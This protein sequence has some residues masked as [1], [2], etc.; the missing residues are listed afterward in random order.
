MDDLQLLRRFVD[1]NSQ[2]AFAALTSR[3][4]GLV[5][6]VCRRELADDQAAEDV[7]QA[8]FLILARKAPILG[9]GVVLSGWLF[10]T[11]RF[12]AKNAR[13]QAQRRTAYEGEAAAMRHEQQQEREDAVWAGIEPVLNQSLA[14]L[15][16]GER[17]CVLLRFFQGL[18]FAEA[19]AALGLSEDTARKRVGRA[20]EKMRRFF[21]KEG[22]IVPGALL[23]ALLTARAAEAV[24]ATLS[25]G[26]P[27]PH[28]YQ[29]STGVLHA[30]KIIQIKTVA[31]VG[32]AATVALGTTYSVARGVSLHATN[33]SKSSVRALAAMPAAAKQGHV[34]A[35]APGKALTAAQ[36]TDRCRAAYGALKSYQGTTTVTSHSTAS[37]NPT[38]GEYRASATI[39]FVRPGKIRAEGKDMSGYPYAYVSDGTATAYQANA[40]KGAWKA[41]PN[42][43]MAIA[44]VTGIAENAA[45][46]VPA[47]LLGAG[48]G[49]PFTSGIASEI[50]EDAVDGHPC[51]V[52]TSSLAK[53]TASMAQTFWIDEKTFLLRRL[54]SDAD[55]SAVSFTIAG[56]KHDVPAAKS[57]DDQ[58]FTGERPNESIPDSVFAVPPTP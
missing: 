11:A 13:T 46:T 40:N 23:A 54:V 9:R 42:T 31:A 24:P 53:P 50:R 4:L 15:P 26:L 32:L 44:S 7:T 22:V 45:T 49:N 18:S 16:S 17:E 19:G 58:R 12:A 14:A 48:W 38:P 21:V 37:T 30:M 41:L 20:L 8:V 39:Q 25:V 5:Y 33:N 3:Y 28:V 55:T 57:H 35:Q 10:Q 27:G 43:T 51:Y 52:V 29:I 1:Q 56:K 36:I 34:L 6:S 47:L 2:E